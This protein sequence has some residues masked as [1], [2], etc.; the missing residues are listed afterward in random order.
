MTSKKPE[1]NVSKMDVLKD[2]R[3]LLS[4]SH[5]LA[6]PKEK[7]AES[8]DK[9]RAEIASLKAEIASYKSQLQSQLDEI[10]RLKNENKSLEQKR[11]DEIQKLKSE[12]KASPQK[13][14]EIEKLKAENKEALQKLQSEIDK[15][16]KESSAVDQKYQKEI[17]ALKAKN[18]ELLAKTPAPAAK[19]QTGLASAA[20]TL[21]TQR[22][23]AQIA[24]LNQALAQV[25][26]LVQLKSKDL[27][28]RL[29]RVYQEAAQGDIAVEF[30]KGRDQLE[31]L[32]NLA[33]FVQALLGE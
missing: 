1:R 4:T 12:P 29:A 10:T 31:S 17:E 22:L 28:S 18:T 26:G 30:K 32:E 23:E 20:S 27:M 13:P 11:L 24:Q 7:A 25:E 19:P 14:G 5:E 15:L 9:S 3:G 6:P 21:E 8:E 33:H 2:I 16:K